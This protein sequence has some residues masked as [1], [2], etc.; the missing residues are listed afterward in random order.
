MLMSLTFLH[1]MQRKFQVR[2]GQRK[3][4]NAAMASNEA[5]MISKPTGKRLFLSL[6]RRTTESL[7]VENKALSHRYILHA[8]KTKESDPHYSTADQ[9]YLC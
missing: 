1:E 5:L 4:R 3:S 8:G 7:R 9:A 2:G 6:R